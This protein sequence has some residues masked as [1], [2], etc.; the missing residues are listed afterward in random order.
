[1]GKE[2]T[3]VEHI[4]PLLTRSRLQETLIVVLD[5]VRPA[6]PDIDY[7]LV[8]TGA[9]LLHGVDLPAGDVDIL[10]KER[11]GVDAF[12]AALASFECL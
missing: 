5:D 8:G 12:G 7:R 4:N 11:A 10:I 2:R 3:N 1:M 9:A 6:Y